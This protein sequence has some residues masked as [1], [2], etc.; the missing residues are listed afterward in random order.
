VIGC[1]IVDQGTPMVALWVFDAGAAAVLGITALFG[2]YF[3]TSVGGCLALA[4]CTA[5]QLHVNDVLSGVALNV[6]SHDRVFALDNLQEHTCRSSWPGGA[7]RRACAASTLSSATCCPAEVNVQGY[8][9]L[10]GQGIFA[11]CS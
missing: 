2:D 1:P 9:V 6:S 8:A 3:D 7:K 4:R 10:D 5:L 11:T